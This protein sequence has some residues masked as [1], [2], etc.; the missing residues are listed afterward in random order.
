MAAAAVGR[1]LSGGIPGHL[2]N[3]EVL[4]KEATR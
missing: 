1:L 2:V 3:P 4:A